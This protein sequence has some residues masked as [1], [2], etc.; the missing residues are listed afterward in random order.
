LISE[1]IQKLRC[2]RTVKAGSCSGRLALDDSVITP[3]YQAQQNEIEEAVLVC[4]QCGAAY[5]VIRGVAVVMDNIQSWL[6]GNYYNLL[7]G[8]HGSG[9][10]GEEL[11]N[12]LESFGWQMSNQPANNYYEA[13]RWVNIFTATHY[14]P[15]QAGADDSSEVGRLIAGQAS[16]FEVIVEM[17]EQHLPG[18]VNKALDVGTNVG[19]MAFRV[20]PFAESV[21]GLDT[22]FNVVLTARRVQKGFPRPL[23]SVKRYMDGHHYDERNIGPFPENTEFMVA[24]A[25]PLPVDENYDLITVLNVIDCVPDPEIFLVSLADVLNPGGFMVVTSPYSWGSDDVPVDRWLGASEKQSSAD[26]LLGLLREQGLEIV[27]ERDNVP[28]VLREHK[29]WY[30]VFHNHC[31]IARKPDEA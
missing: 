16:V 31:V 2:P 29:R 15:V 21:L 11:T 28:W 14:D 23:K 4:Q 18:K 5:P 19:G 9:G 22:A 30:R 3:I 20:A 17:L 12:W 26:A 6:R 10:M 25:V 7:S 1:L 24:S 8:A 13:P 27:E